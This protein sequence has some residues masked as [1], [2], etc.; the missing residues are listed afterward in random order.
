MNNK[1]LTKLQ[2][3]QYAMLVEITRICKKY[4]IKYYLAY[5]TLLG[6]VRH[7][8]SIPWDYDIDIFMDRSNYNKFINVSKE[9]SNIYEIGHVGSGKNSMSGLTRVYKKNTLIYT[10]EHGK[11]G[12]FPIHI[13]IFILDYKKEYSRLLEVIVDNLVA[14]LSV[15]KLSHYEKEWLYEHFKNNFIKKSVI[16]S[17]NIFRKIFGEDGIEKFV[18]KILVSKKGSN[19][20]ITVPNHKSK[21]PCRWFRESVIMEYEDDLY[22]VPL[23]YDKLLTLLYGDYMT[24]PPVE[25]RFTQGM[26]RFKIKWK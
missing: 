18:Y 20:Y 9:L 26:E 13:D 2:N 21:L 23:E 17:G 19:N 16:K 12:A 14:Y 10:E 15:A 6:A 22:T 4:K 5:G 8:G 25:K 11:K 1:D 7:H 3:T 24:P